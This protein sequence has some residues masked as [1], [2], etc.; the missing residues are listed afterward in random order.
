MTCDGAYLYYTERPASA[1]P[2]LW[3]ISRTTGAAVA[4]GG[5]TEYD[6]DLLRANG[7][8][9]AGIAPNSSA[10]K[11]VHWSTGG[12]PVELTT[13]TPTTNLNGL[14]IDATQVYV[15]G[16]R[17]T[18]DVWCYTTAGVAVWSITLPSSSTPVVNAIA[19]DG[20]MVYVATDQ[21]ALTAG[22]KASIFCLSRLDGSLLWT[23]DTNTDLLRVA[24]DDRYL[25]VIDSFDILTMLRLHTPAVSPLAELADWDEVICDGVSVIGHDATTTDNY[26]R[27]YLG[28]PAKTFMRADGGDT[29]RRPFFTLAVPVD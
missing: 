23:H 19:A 2:G 24:V 10:G 20:D 9:A 15:G 25:F 22:G 26:M 28:G 18:Q 16:T 17:N 27:H 1:L 13:N 8:H 29:T 14:A 3:K 21:A 4:N 6:C 5:T 11:V 7:T 12:T